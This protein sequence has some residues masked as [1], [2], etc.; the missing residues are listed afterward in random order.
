[1][2]KILGQALGA[3]AL[4]AVM[5]YAFAGDYSGT[6]RPYFYSDNLYIEEVS[7]QKSNLPACAKRPLLRLPA[8]PA[9]PA[10]KNE[11]AML[12]SAWYTGR[13]LL[14]SGSG[15]CTSEGDEVVFV[16]TPQ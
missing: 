1:M 12:L 4:L 8:D 9:S 10:F 15:N 3:T 16:I 13:T 5:P 11:Y 2:K 14:I 6:F 7:V